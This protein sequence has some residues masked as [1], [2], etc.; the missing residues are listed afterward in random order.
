MLT[1]RVTSLNGAALPR[2]IEA[3][4]GE[5]G[6]TIGRADANGLVLP[7]AE[8]HIS[9]LHARIAYRSG[10]FE[11]VDQGSNPITMYSVRC[12]VTV[13]IKNRLRTPSLSTTSAP[14]IADRLIALGRAAGPLT[15]D[16]TIAVLRHSDSRQSTGNGSPATSAA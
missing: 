9:R 14:G 7:D 8:R 12:G 10:A 11:L 5:A 3:A 15:D 6:G 16:L 2:P 13:Q 1:L 4:F